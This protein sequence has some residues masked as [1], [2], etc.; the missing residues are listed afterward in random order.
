VSE[1]QDQS[2]QGRISF[3]LRI[4]VTGHRHLHNER[5]L[6]RQVTRAVERIRKLAPSSP[7]T[8]VVFSV[9][10]PLAE[11]ADRL[12]AREV[13][14][15]EGAHL[16]V[17]LPLPRH[18][19]MRDFESDASKREFD[20]LATRSREVTLLASTGSREDASQRLGRYVVDRCDV[21][22]ALWDGKA[23]QGPGGTAEVVSYARHR[24]V[25]LIWIST[26]GQHEITEELGSGLSHESFRRLDQFNRARIAQERFKQQV[27][28]RQTRLLTA[29]RSSGVDPLPAKALS[30]W[31]APFY[32]RA[33]LLAMRYQ[34]VYYALANA[35]FLLAAAAVALVAIEALIT[36]E[37]RGLVWGE[38]GL[39]LGLL[40]IV[41]IGRRWQFHERWL[42]YRFLAERFRSA[43]FLALTGLS[44][45]RE[46]GLERIQLGHPSEEWLRRSFSEV[47]SQREQPQMGQPNIEGL[48]RFLIEDWIEHQIGY[49]RKMSQKHHRRHQRLTWASVALFSATV[50]AGAL[51][52]LNVAGDASPQELSWA[53]VLI[54]LAI[55]MPALG[56]A[57]SGIRAQREYLRHS[58]RSDRMV[59]Y[60]QSVKMRMAAAPD[61]ETVRQV[62]AD[63]ED[64]ML[65]ENRDWF[66]VMKFHDFE[67]SV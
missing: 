1:L 12:V 39:M 54:L 55:A 62:A 57:L 7:Y 2:G 26:E 43:F 61:T 48:R 24:N 5:M 9:V 28:S 6:A 59:H 37:T 51:H 25:P 32:V 50:L 42:S 3:R 35:I 4:G 33:D 44:G 49:H 41:G 52:A 8:E 67:L 36:P 63:A 16:E 20:E 17:P 10:S 11:G 64:L 23:S 27:H 34:P 40:L 29:A 19:Y 47:W 56:A 66:I 46:G 22:I 58:E 38:V 18:E 13:L 45:R 15:D 31:V 21:L 30:A 14:K 53:S 60:L 65:E